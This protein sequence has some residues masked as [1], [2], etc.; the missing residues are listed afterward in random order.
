ME[1]MT[2]GEVTV[3]IV[4]AMVPFLVVAGLLSFSGQ[5]RRREAV[6]VARQI[7]V[8]DAIHRELGPVAAPAVGRDWLGG[9]TVSVAV[10]F[11]QEG[12]VS[13]VARI[14]YECFATLHPVDLAGSE[15]SS[16]RW[17]AS[18][19]C[20]R[21]R[22]LRSPAWPVTSPGLPETIHRQEENTMKRSPS[23][24]RVPG[25]MTRPSRR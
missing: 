3:S 4:V 19:C 1:L 16:G 22:R 7:A 5:L 2:L 9:W 11:E 13:A 18:P 21:P 25:T 10:P 6:R 14:A 12:T 24:V 20:D 23:V 15:S 8:T 17:S